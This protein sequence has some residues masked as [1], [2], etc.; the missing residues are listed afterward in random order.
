ML[1][2]ILEYAR[3]RA[4]RAHAMFAAESSILVPLVQSNK[5]FELLIIDHGNTT[6]LLERASAFALGV[7]DGNFSSLIRSNDTGLAKGRTAGYGT[8]RNSALE[9]GIKIGL[10]MTSNRVGTLTASWIGESVH[11][12]GRRGR[13]V[14]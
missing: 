1:T 14:R 9:D 5:F 10:Y 7:V 8:I 4:L 11:R 3:S 12:V 6:R 2:E 13:S